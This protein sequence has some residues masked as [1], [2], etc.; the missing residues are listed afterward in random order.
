MVRFVFAAL[1]TILALAL[2]LGGRAFGLYP[3]FVVC[4]SGFGFCGPGSGRPVDVRATVEEAPRWSGTPFAGRGWHDGIQVGIEPGFVERFAG[5]TGEDPDA[6]RSALVDSV[7]IWETPELRFDIQFDAP[8]VEG[9]GPG[10]GLEIDIFLV[11]QTHPFF[12]GNTA[13]G[14]GTI[15]PVF[16]TNRLLTSGELLPGYSIIGGDVLIAL[17]RFESYFSLLVGVGG[18]DDRLARLL[19]VVAHEVGHTLGYLHPNEWPNF[20]TD[21]DPLTPVIVDPLDPA[22]GLA[23]SSNFDPAAIMLGI[24][25]DPA[26][27]F[28]TELQADDRSGRDVLYPTLVPEPG[29]GLLVLAGLLGLAAG[30]GGQLAR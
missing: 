17:D 22:A 16:Q 14:F 9:T 28:V 5:E 3:G 27:A 8:V 13:T 19:N 4:G 10:G 24:H 7:R 1:P 21:D 23:L 20:D 11:D 6:I 18:G 25:P 29:T 12:Q 2:P 30:R 15:D 26:F